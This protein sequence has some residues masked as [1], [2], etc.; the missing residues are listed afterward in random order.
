[1]RSAPPDKRAASRQ[2]KEGGWRREVGGVVTVELKGR[3]EGKGRGGE[4][5]R[6]QGRR[7]EGEDTWVEERQRK[8]RVRLLLA[9]IPAGH[10]DCTWSAMVA[11]LRGRRQV[12][13]SV[14]SAQEI[15]QSSRRLY[16]RPST[17]WAYK[18]LSVMAQRITRCTTLFWQLSNHM[19]FLESDIFSIRARCIQKSF[20]I[21]KSVSFSWSSYKPSYHIGCRGIHTLQQNY[22]R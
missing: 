14:S 3:Q 19:A 15:G 4:K 5:R 7:D 9:K 2:G 10:C 12:S 18:T 22:F 6:E 1:M 17:N 11:T 21:I 8:E 16:L 20:R 13:V